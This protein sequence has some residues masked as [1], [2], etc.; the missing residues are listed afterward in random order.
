MGSPNLDWLGFETPVKIELDSGLVRRISSLR[1]TA[2]GGLLT[3]DGQGDTA[4]ELVQTPRSV[5]PLSTSTFP[6]DVS[7]EDTKSLPTIGSSKK[8]CGDGKNENTPLSK[9][10]IENTQ[11]QDNYNVDNH[12]NAKAN[13]TKS[14]LRPRIAVN[15]NVN[16]NTSSTSADSEQATFIPF[17]GP[18]GSSN[19]GS[20]TSPLGMS[21]DQLPASCREGLQRSSHE[22]GEKATQANDPLSRYAKNN[23]GNIPHERTDVEVAEKVRNIL[24]P[25][26]KTDEQARLH[27]DDE[28]ATW[29][30]VVRDDF[31]DPVFQDY[32]KYAAL[33]AGNS[34]GN[35][36]RCFPGL[37]SFVGQTGSGK[38]TLIKLLIDLQYG[39]SDPFPSPVVASAISSQDLPTS[40]DV[41]LYGDPHTYSTQ[42]PILYAD[43]EG[44][45]GGEREP[46]EAK[47]RRKHRSEAHRSNSFQ[48]RIRKLHQ[49]AEREISWAITPEK[50]TREFFVGN[51]YPRLLFTFS[52]VIVFVLKNPK[53]RWRGPLHFQTYNSG[54]LLKA[55]YIS[56]TN[57]IASVIES[58][59]ETLLRWADEA[60]EKSSNQPVLPHAVIALNGWNNCSRS[61]WWDVDSATDM[62]M[63]SVNK[64]IDQDPKLKPY[65]DFWRSKGQKIDSLASLLFCYYSDVKVVCVPQ[66]GRPNL[67]D[68]QIDKLYRTIRVAAESSLSQKKSLRMLLDGN[69]LQ[70]YLQYAF[71]HFTSDLDTPF[72]FVQASFAN[73]PI[74]LD[75]GG[76]ILKLALSVH[77]CNPATNVADIFVLLSGMIGSCI[78]L[79]AAKHRPRGI[80][81]QHVVR[82]GI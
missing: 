36:Q 19:L 68:D 64:A 81:Q 2:S 10:R 56:D 46:L 7:S 63:T 1:D 79:D 45:D 74:P 32:G 15:T 34:L 30:G 49:T 69:K 21:G 48:K 59:F 77:R 9:F 58:V 5:N 54:V 20:N 78:M 26:R 57:A 80:Y 51:L 31:N 22:Q 44:L 16:Y 27:K 76:N 72:D 8:V 25:K 11:C 65:A 73:N 29:F 43:C 55:T 61:E 23:T 75:F 37:V 60:L 82:L 24:E 4:D 28:D 47:S 53:N 52:D 41:H 66:N 38:S 33:I 71:D 67:M 39:D 14:S 13:E 40:G 3:E 50:R 17:T 35:S 12:E 70:P 62:L 6:T 42:Y 18:S